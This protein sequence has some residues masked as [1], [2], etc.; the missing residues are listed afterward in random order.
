MCWISR[1]HSPSLLI[2]NGEHYKPMEVGL[3]WYICYK[4]SRLTLRPLTLR[5]LVLA[6]T[7]SRLLSLSHKST[8]VYLFRIPVVLSII[9][10]TLNHCIICP[11]FSWEF[12]RLSH[13][14][15]FFWRPSTVI[16]FC[17][18]YLF[19]DNLCFFWRYG[20][21]D[22]SSDEF[23]LGKSVVF[24]LSALTMRGWSVVPEKLSSRVAFA[25]SVL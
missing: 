5:L 23:T 13:H 22:P 15:L 17:I 7:S 14:Q 11:G 24:V 4:P 2:C 3:G 6:A 19:R 9:W 20:L 16:I 1:L 12:S 18:N 21:Y 10:L 8:T 25:V